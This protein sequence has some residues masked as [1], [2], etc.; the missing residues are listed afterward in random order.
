MAK[1]KKKL[2]LDDA[3]LSAAANAVEQLGLE[4]PLPAWGEEIRVFNGNL[5]VDG[6]LLLDEVL[7]LFVHGDLTVKGDILNLN[8]DVGAVLVV[9]GSLQARNLIAGGSEV[10]VSGN[11]KVKNTIYGYYNHG[12]M[13]INGDTKAKAVICDDHN[14]SLEGNVTAPIV[15]TGNLPS[16]FSD[17][18]KVL[19][20]QVVDHEGN[21]DHQALIGWLTDKNKKPVRSNAK[22][23]RI[24]VEEEVR[25]LGEESVETICLRQRELGEFPEALFALGALRN[26]DLS[27]NSL[28]KLPDSIGQMTNLRVLDLSATDLQSL[29]QSLGDLCKLEELYLASNFELGALPASMA[30]LSSLR[31]LHL[32][33]CRSLATVPFVDLTTLEELDIRYVGK[34][35]GE[36]VSAV[37]NLRVLKVD[38]LVHALPNQLAQLDAL[39][40]LSL[41]KSPLVMEQGIPSVVFELTGLKRLDLGYNPLPQF[42]PELGQMKGLEELNLGYSL[43]NTEDLPDLSGLISLKSLRLDGSFESGK[44]PPRPELIDR[45]LRLEG[46]RKLDL[47][48]WS[49]KEGP[50]RSRGNLALRSDCFQMLRS[51]TSIRLRFSGLRDLPPSLYE[52][53]HL[54]EIDVSGNEDLTPETIERLGA[55]FPN[56]KIDLRGVRA[57]G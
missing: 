26:L 28:Q 21:V 20:K 29:P 49:E 55:T 22:A 36:D 39:E 37:K 10:R 38:G 4:E 1:G 54:E 12:T 42:P 3:V 24:I 27:S 50:T 25:M 40:E 9:E 56:A 57:A 19:V 13:I 45:V 48:G 35:I 47:S 41:V 7:D 8:G 53:E 52:L 18:S 31:V 16:D 23:T 2:S 33:H 44:E 34:P 14:M 32:M 46:L 15:S 30:N 51:L 11:A 6:D 17:I 43:S 5:T